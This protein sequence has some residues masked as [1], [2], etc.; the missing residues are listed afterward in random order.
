MQYFDMGLRWMNPQN[1][2]NAMPA[3]SFKICCLEYI[4]FEEDWF[5]YYLMYLKFMPSQK[6]Y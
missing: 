1:Y 5:L 6:Y 4:S 3:I 2:F